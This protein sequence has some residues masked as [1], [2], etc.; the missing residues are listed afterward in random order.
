MSYVYSRMFQRRL[1]NQ[2]IYSYY[3][4]RDLFPLQQCFKFKA[5]GGYELADQCRKDDTK[6]GPQGTF[7]FRKMSDA[8]E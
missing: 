7:W 1:C 8:K 4:P 6:C 5:K 2:C 3:H